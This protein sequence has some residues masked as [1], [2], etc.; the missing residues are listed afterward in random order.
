VEEEEVAVVE[1]DEVDHRGPVKIGGVLWVVSHSFNYLSI[2][3]CCMSVSL[4]TMCKKTKNYCFGCTA[5]LTAK[6]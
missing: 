3:S 6:C 4:L 5:D 1:D 2:V